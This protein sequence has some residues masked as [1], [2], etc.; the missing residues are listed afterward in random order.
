MEPKKQKLNN[1]DAAEYLGIRPDTLATWRC[2]HKG[3]RYAKIGTRVLY[4]LADL[5]D[6]F[7]ARAVDTMDST[8]N[9]RRYR[10]GR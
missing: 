7:R 4:D 6:F 5:E 3:P 1:N 2:K 9:V 8:P 10:G